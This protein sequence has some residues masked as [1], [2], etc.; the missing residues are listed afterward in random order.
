MT[1]AFL[2]PLFLY[3]LAAA[4]AP[5]LI[6]LINR[7]RAKPLR[8]PAVRFVL[9]ANQR[10]ARRYKLRQ[11]LL[12][13][14]RTLA[15][16]VFASVLARPV[17]TE[18]GTLLTGG[19]PPVALVVI[20]DTSM[21]L[22]YSGATGLR[23]DSA[24]ALL[25]SY[26]EQ[27]RSEDSVALLATN[28]DQ[29]AAPQLSSEVSRVRGAAARL[30]PTFG[31]ADFRAAIA[32]AY[33]LL[34]TSAATR[35]QILI[36]TDRQ[37]AGWSSFDAGAIDKV[38]PDVLMQVVRIGGARPDENRTVERLALKGNIIGSDVPTVLEA[39]VENFSPSSC[40]AGATSW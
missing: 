29:P 34:S 10:I 4:G 1:F 37:E 38:D 25:D 30:Q 23:M 12:L 3:G 35:K 21:S 13:A 11:L 24:R 31:R 9:R 5:V 2:N 27:L 36:L 20:F 33:Q 22:G 39:S 18:E 14:L 7:R 19:G 26:L 6:H 15:I 32:N 28:A 16:L 17:L 40:C 8:F